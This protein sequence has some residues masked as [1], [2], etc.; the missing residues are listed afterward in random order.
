MDSVS[1]TREVQFLGAW[2]Q[3][4]RGPV[5]LEGGNSGLGG[6]VHSGSNGTQGFG[7]FR[8]SGTGFDVGAGQTVRLPKSG[9]FRVPLLGEGP[10]EGRSPAIGQPLGDRRGPVP[11]TGVLRK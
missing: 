10:L 4:G 1:P 5:N 11:R 9:T 3:E 6:G 8:V 7:G 2:L